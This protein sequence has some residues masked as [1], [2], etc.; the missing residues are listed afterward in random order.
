MHLLHAL[1]ISQLAIIQFLIFVFIFTFLTYGVFTPY[2]KALME[3]EKRTVGGEALAE[4][5]QQKTI[6]LSTEYQNQARAINTQIQEIFQRNRNEANAAYDRVVGAAREEASQMIEKNRAQISQAVGAAQND[7][8][9][10]T[11]AVALAITNK[12]L[13]K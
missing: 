9:G 4:E 6:E 12:L 7:L 10:Q 8:R 5:Y 3:R 13:G 2:F 1:G 11:T